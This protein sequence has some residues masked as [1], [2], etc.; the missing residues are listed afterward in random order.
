MQ[1]NF[2]VFIPEKTI[3]FAKFSALETIIY[4]VFIAAAISIVYS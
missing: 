4:R 2:F 3:K 1:I